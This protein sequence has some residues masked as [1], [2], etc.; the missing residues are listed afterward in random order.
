MER[1]K[2]VIKKI[3]HQ[4]ASQLKQDYS[5]STSKTETPPLKWIKNASGEKVAIFNVNPY[6]ASSESA[7]KL[8]RKVTVKK[9]IP[10]PAQ[11]NKMKT[12]SY[13]SFEKEFLEK[14]ANESEQDQDGVESDVENT[15]FL[16]EEQGLAFHVKLY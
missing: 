2:V 12:N 11:Q 13:S 14:T 7:L 10:P 4:K 9:I 15:E 6:Q 3:L 1:K 8:L 5:N 16:S